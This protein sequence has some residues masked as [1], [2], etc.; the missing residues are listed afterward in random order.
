MESE[1]SKFVDEN[2][3]TIEQ[4]NSELEKI[5]DQIPEGE[6]TFNF[7]LDFN[8]DLQYIE[9]PEVTIVE[10]EGIEA[11]PYDWT[12]IEE[13][14]YNVEIVEEIAADMDDDVNK[15]PDSVDHLQKWIDE[16][17]AKAKHWVE[18]HQKT[19]NKVNNFIDL[20][21][22]D[23]KEALNKL[24]GKMDRWIKKHPKA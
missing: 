18:K 23:P 13:P 3:E 7:D 24:D 14:I 19:V 1:V 17:D 16:V 4:I 10:F 20:L 21:N 9:E 2:P 8:V 6:F 22:D 11:Y 12:V 5:P 15:Q